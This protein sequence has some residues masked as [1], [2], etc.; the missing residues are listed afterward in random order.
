MA[1]AAEG[2]LALL[3][4]S[5]EDRIASYKYTVAPSQPVTLVCIEF[6]NSKDRLSFYELCCVVG[7]QVGAA[8]ELQEKKLNE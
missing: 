6:K 4:P 2:P 8:R 3:F 1:P 7:E 5:A